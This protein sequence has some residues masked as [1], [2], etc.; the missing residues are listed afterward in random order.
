MYFVDFNYAVDALVHS[1]FSKIGT[2][3]G[4]KYLSHRNAVIISINVQLGVLLHSDTL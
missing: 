1:Q 2:K 3:S 4:T